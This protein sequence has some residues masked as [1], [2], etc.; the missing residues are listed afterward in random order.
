VAL[1]AL[2]VAL[3]LAACDTSAPRPVPTATAS[4]VFGSTGAFDDGF[5]GAEIAQG[6]SDYASGTIAVRVEALVADVEVHSVVLSGVALR[7]SVEWR[8]GAIVPD[9]AARDL[10]MTFPGAACATDDRATEVVIDYTVAGVRRTPVL[11]PADPLGVIARLV[12]RDCLVQDVAAIAKL[13]LASASPDVASGDGAGVLELSVDP[14][15][16]EG[17]ASFT[18]E[19]V[20]ATTLLA[21]AGGGAGWPVDRVVTAGDA[22][23]T[24]RLDVVPARCDAH[25]VAED[26]VGTVMPVRIR[27]G[28]GDGVVPVAASDEVRAALYDLVA[29]SCGW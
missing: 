26:K 28:A 15:N 7:G 29:R 18:I 2:G 17:D 9:G 5:V 22:P 12:D 8:E 20:D 11:E 23:S 27:L 16:A 25:A 24:I 6:R 3:G 4:L 21:P 10:R 14:S 19:S 13:G 1:L